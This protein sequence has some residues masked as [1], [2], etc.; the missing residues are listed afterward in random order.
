MLRPPYLFLRYFAHELKFSS[1]SFPSG[2]RDALEEVGDDSFCKGKEKYDYIFCECRKVLSFFALCLIYHF[3]KYDL[4]EYV[5]LG[6]RKSIYDMAFMLILLILLSLHL[7][8]NK[9]AHI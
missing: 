7:S 2:W 9:S 8:L 3:D 4:L 5:Q 6:A 1:C